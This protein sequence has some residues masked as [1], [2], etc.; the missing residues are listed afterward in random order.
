MSKQKNKLKR[1]K[2][3]LIAVGYIAIYYAVSALC[4]LLYIVWQSGVGDISLSQMEINVTN[5]S[6]PLSVISV[7]LT[8]WIYLL[9]GKLRNIPLT[10]VVKSES[11][12]LMVNIMAAMLAVGMRLLVTVYYSW[13]Q[14]IELLKK[15]IDEAA[16]LSPQFTSGVQLLIGVFAIIVIAP[17]FEEI[18]FRGIVFCELKSIMR[19]WAA[20]ILQAL[21]FGIAHAVLFQSIF[22]FIVGIILGV[23]YHRTQSIKTSAI[24]HSVFNLSVIFA[25]SELTAISGSVLALLGLL[26]SICSL[27]YILR[28]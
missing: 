3:I 11:V 5:A 25:Q 16:S 21:L 9:I 8:L 1:I 14:N 13:S 18:L 4:Q 6:Y 22:A 19:N 17:F 10:S 20:N 24:C 2:A 27:Y 15:S 12:P 28:Q 7:I 23:V 26:L